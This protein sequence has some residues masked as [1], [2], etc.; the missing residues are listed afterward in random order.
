M[1]FGAPRGN[2]TFAWIYRNWTCNPLTIRGLDGGG[3]GI[4]TH[5]T[6]RLSSFQD[7]RNRPLYHPSGAQSRKGYG[8]GS[9]G[10]Q[11]KLLAIS[12][13]FPGHPPEK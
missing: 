6:L 1:R 11:A 3:G 4:R 13:P 2:V 7:W 10:F 8:E 5:G 9:A 12:N